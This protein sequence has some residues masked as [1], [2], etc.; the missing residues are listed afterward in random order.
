MRVMTDLRQ[1]E[2][3]EGSGRP[4][5]ETTILGKAPREPRGSCQ[6]CFRPMPLLMGFMIPE[7]QK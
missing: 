3:C 5:A 2:R 1:A 4:P 7:H 6:R